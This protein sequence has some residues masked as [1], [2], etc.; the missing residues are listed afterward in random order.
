M[1]RRLAYTFGNHMHWVDMQ[2]LWGDDVLPGSI[3]DMRR[4][5]QSYGVRGCVNFDA[6]GYEKLAQ[7]RPEAL[8]ELRSIVQTNQIEVVGGSYGQ[9]YGLFQTGESNVRQLVFGVRTC[10][11]HLGVAPRTFWEEEFYWFP[12]LPQMLAKSGYAGASLFFQWT[13]HTPEVPKEDSPVVWWEG[14][15]GSRLLAATRNR[16]NL[17]QWPEDMAILLDELSSEETGHG[18]PELIQQWLE[19]MP[20]RDWMCRAEVIGPGLERLLSDE[21]FE[22]EPITLG[23]YLARWK[24]VSVPVRRYGI[25]DVWHGFTLG[26]AGDQ[27]QAE[28]TR[29]SNDLTALEAAFAEASLAGRPYATWDVYPDW[30]L[31]EAWRSLLAAQHHDCVECIGLCGRVAFAILEQGRQIVD[32]LTR[33]L[34]AHGFSPATPE[35]RQENFEWRVGTPFS[36]L[37]KEVF[38][39]HGVEACFVIGRYESIS[40][41]EHCLRL[42]PATFTSGLE[43]S[44]ESHFPELLRFETGYEGSLRLEL[45]ADIRRMR[46]HL[47]FSSEE[48]NVLMNG[49]RKYPTGDWMTSPQVFETIEGAFYSGEGLDLELASGEWLYIDG[50]V[51]SGFKTDDGIQI[52][53]ASY[54]PW[55]QDYPVGDHPLEFRRRLTFRFGPFERTSARRRSFRGN[56]GGKAFSW[57]AQGSVVEAFYREHEDHGRH[58][59]NY[60]GTG[61]HMPFV[62]RL[63]EYDGEPDSVVLKFR[64]EVARAYQTNLLGEIVRELPVEDGHTVRLEMRPHEIATLYLD[65][66]DGRKQY[67]DLDAKR[68]IWATIHRQGEET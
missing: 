4:L 29:L 18:H 52:V 40:N 68:H 25:G 15:D 13:W 64:S 8:A 17:H 55:H 53:I 1:K 14:V 6:I 11:N 20:S 58:S 47:P 45:T 3:R 39:A 42:Y 44:I 61:M 21:R 66:V 16:L 60:A 31:R 59:R 36:S 22:I 9:P 23:E 62:L 65:L 49:V 37:A 63:V 41:P 38:G 10:Q 54:D 33:R 51:L 48:G 50:E 35:H 2:W 30:E 26:T 67:R 56:L 57:H 46:V 12:Q 27:F 5:S 34:K 19:L 32:R 7:D 43:L 24:G 28:L